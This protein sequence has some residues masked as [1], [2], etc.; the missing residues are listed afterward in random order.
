MIFLQGYRLYFMHANYTDVRTV[1]I[2]AANE[3]GDQEMNPLGNSTTGME[4]VQDQKLA[5]NNLEEQFDKEEME[6]KLTR[7]GKTPSGTSA[8][9]I[10]CSKV[11]L[12]FLA[13]AGI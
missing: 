12:P 5:L 6:Y 4:N 10:I 8:Q 11:L 1:R 3:D 13:I 2:K 7:L 9:S